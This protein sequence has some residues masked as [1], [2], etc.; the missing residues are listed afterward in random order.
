[1]SEKVEIYIKHNEIMKA[2]EKMAEE[3]NNEYGDKF[4]VFIVILKGAFM[5]ASELMKRINCPLNIDFMTVSSYGPYT[6]SSGN[7]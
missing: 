5:F 3:L 4:P 6:K 1:M 2:I 7:V